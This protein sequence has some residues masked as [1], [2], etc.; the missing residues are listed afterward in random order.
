MGVKYVATKPN[1][2]PRLKIDWIF[3][4]GAVKPVAATIVRDGRNDHY[5]SDHYFVSA[6]VEI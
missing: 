1:G 6:E 3:S 2:E 5:P 4:R